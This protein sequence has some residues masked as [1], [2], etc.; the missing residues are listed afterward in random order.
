[1]VLERLGRLA[2]LCE[3]PR[4]D[5]AFYCLVRVK[6]ALDPVTLASRL[7]AEHRVAAVP[8]SAFGLTDGCYLRV[9]YGALDPGDVAEGLTRLI[10]GIAT[11]TGRER[12][13][14]WRV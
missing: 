5:G 9:S 3:V 10:D 8:G 6:T 12:V 13:S 4:P 2:G 14:G 11:I 1:M 7:I